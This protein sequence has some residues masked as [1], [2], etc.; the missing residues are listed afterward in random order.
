MWGNAGCLEP[1]A[2]FTNCITL[3]VAADLPFG[4]QDDGTVESPWLLQ[5]PSGPLDFFNVNLGDGTGQPDRTK[6]AVAP[7]DFVTAVPA[8]PAAG[9]SNANL[10][11]DPT[12]NTPDISGSGLLALVAPFTF[13]SGTK[14]QTSGQY[15]S[16]PIF[17]PSAAMGS[18]VHVWTQFPPGDPGLLAIGADTSDP[19]CTTSF[20]SFDGYVTPA[21]LADPNWALR[22]KP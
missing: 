22:A 8:Y 9:V 11:L 15:I 12:G 21:Q 5:I 10:L 4:E 19:G 2:G 17:V 1:G 7:A 14:A 16:Q 3:I 18:N 13:P 20:V 6:L